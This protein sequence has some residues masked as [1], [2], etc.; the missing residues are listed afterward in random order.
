LG[1]RLVLALYA[2]L[3]LGYSVLLPVW[4]PPDEWNQY[5]V[6]IRLIRP[7]VIQSP[8]RNPQTRH[9]HVYYW[10][11]SAPLRALNAFDSELVE[12]F[13]PK[14]RMEGRGQWFRYKWSAGNYRFI[15]GVY[16]LRWLNVLM[17]GFTLYFILKAAKKF[18]PPLSEVPLAAVS[19]AALTPQFLHINAS[20]SNGPLSYLA[21]A[22]L[23]WLLSRLCS[24]TP[25]WWDY[26]WAA[27]FALAL[28][29]ATKLTLLP[30]AL[31]VLLAILWRT[32]IYWRTHWLRLLVGASALVASILIV[33]TVLMPEAGNSFGQQLLNRILAI[34]PEASLPHSIAW[35]IRSYWGLIGGFTH[36]QKHI[37]RRD[38]PTLTNILFDSR[39]D[40]VGMPGSMALFLTIIASLGALVSLLVITHRS[41]SLRRNFAFGN[42]MAWAM[43]WIAALLSIA[44]IL[45]NALATSNAQGRHIFPSIGVLALLIA[46]GWL[47]LVPPRF[48]AFAPYVVCALLTALNL[49][50]WFGGIIPIYHQPFLD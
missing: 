7:I 28:P 42:K 10:L 27:V 32:R 16:V 45:S 33:L 1:F 8:E 20:V 38:D 30:M 49:Y 9:P 39:E 24:G 31:T 44:A 47:A 12:N 5:A 34:R 36:I 35:L 46:N 29:F 17:G 6:A 18:A 13:H 43:L 50:L 11:A 14:K 25:S 23:F 41:V 48:S 26:G 3:G 21:G 2:C 22:F 40:D 4:E 37:E 19:L 15:A